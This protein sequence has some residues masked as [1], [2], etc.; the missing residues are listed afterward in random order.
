VCVGELRLRRGAALRASCVVLRLR[1]GAALRASCVVCVAG[2]LWRYVWDVKKLR[3]PFSVRGC[4]SNCL[5]PL[6]RAVWGVGCVNRLRGIRVSVGLGGAV[7]VAP[8]LRC[9]AMAA[10]PQMRKQLVP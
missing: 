3:I 6:P 1:R 10:A 2:L 9:G 8:R 4:S 5:P 7:S